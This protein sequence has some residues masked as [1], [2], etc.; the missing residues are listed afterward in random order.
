VGSHLQLSNGKTRGWFF[1][2][3]TLKNVSFSWQNLV[4]KVNTKKIENPLLPMPDTE[5]FKFS[6]SF[7]ISEVLQ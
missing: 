1:N 2:V 7:P 6:H 5:A 4:E 3:G